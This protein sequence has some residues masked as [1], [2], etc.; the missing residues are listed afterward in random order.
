MSYASK[1]TMVF[2]SVGLR[3]S[4]SHWIGPHGRCLG[5]ENAEKAGSFGALFIW[6][7]HQQ[8]APHSISSPSEP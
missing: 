5:L 1:Y 6:G 8:M 3:V 4:G 2:G 7:S